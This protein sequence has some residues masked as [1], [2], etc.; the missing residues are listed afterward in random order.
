MPL[1]PIITFV[2]SLPTTSCS[3]WPTSSPSKTPLPPPI[4]LMTVLLG[5]VLLVLTVVSILWLLTVSCHVFSTGQIQAILGFLLYF[6]LH[7][8]T[9]LHILSCSFALYHAPITIP[10]HIFTLSLFTLGISSRILATA[11]FAFFPSHLHF[12]SHSL[13]F[14]SLGL[15]QSV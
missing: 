13:A 6:P 7:P 14:L 15:A 10:S 12:L 9:F 8:I 5:G 11:S 3:A 4:I 1:Q 2:S